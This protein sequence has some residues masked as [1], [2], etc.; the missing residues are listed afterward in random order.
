LKNT[1][2]GV[3]SDQAQAKKAIEKNS[4]SPERGEGKNQITPYVIWIWQI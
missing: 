3:Q 2:F 1:G 4:L